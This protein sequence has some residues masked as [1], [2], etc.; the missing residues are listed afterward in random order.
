VD[1]GA[2]ASISDEAPGPSSS[3]DTLADRGRRLFEFLAQ[4]QLLKTK[5]P[6]TTDAYLHDGSVLWM[7]GLP[8]HLAVRSAHLSPNQSPNSPYLSLSA[9]PLPPLPLS[10]TP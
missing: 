10:P 1:T 5:P 8:E 2:H 3:G 6:L 9:S 4:A 7:R